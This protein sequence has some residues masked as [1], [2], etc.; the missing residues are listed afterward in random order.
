MQKNLRPRNPFLFLWGERLNKITYYGSEKDIQ[1]AIETLKKCKSLRT[2]DEGTARLKIQKLIDDQGLKASI[3]I[4]GNTV[5]SKKRI[6][7]N[8]RRIL[9]HGTL[10]NEDQDKPPILSH[11]FY[12]FLHLCCGS[13]AHYDIH[14]WIHKYPRVE[15]LKKFFM[16]NEWGKRVRDNIPTWHTDVKVIVEEI[17]RA[18]FPF[19]AYMKTLNHSA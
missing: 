8:L 10:Y 1:K 5:W 18:L 3:L 4:N 13:I 6:L 2:S 11:Y 19:Q 17:E 15:D 7:K 16:K 9:T 14:G 12:E